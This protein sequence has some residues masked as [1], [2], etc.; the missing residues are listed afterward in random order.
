MMYERCLQAGV[1]TGFVLS[2]WTAYMIVTHP[3]S[4]PIKYWAFFI[5]GLMG[6]TL[7]YASLLQYRTRPSVTSNI[8]AV[9]TALLIMCVVLSFLILTRRERVPVSL[10]GTVAILH[11]FASG[12]LTLHIA[13][14]Y[15]II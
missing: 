9:Q 12:T 7:S 1:F 11:G 13:S 3:Y 15:Q 5:I 6:A 10:L 4:Y 2:F 14:Q 8:Q